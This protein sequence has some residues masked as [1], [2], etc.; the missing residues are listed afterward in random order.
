[1]SKYIKEKDNEIFV[2]NTR[3]KEIPHYLS[4]LKT[5]RLG[6]QA[7]DINGKYIDPAYM[8]PMF[9]GK[10]EEYEYDRIRMERFNKI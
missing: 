4:S 5:I 7:L 2:G 10:S 8:R 3:E 1:M 9:I 6:K